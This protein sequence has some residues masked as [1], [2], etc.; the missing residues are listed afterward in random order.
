MDL[1]KGKGTDPELSKCLDFNIFVY[2]GFVREVNGEWR[3]VGD[4]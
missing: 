2:Y 1:T 4:F 3:V